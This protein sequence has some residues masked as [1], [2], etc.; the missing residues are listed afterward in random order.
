MLWQHAGGT[1]SI[2]IQ[3]EFGGDGGLEEA[4][5]LVE[6]YHIKWFGRV[7]HKTKQ[8]SRLAN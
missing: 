6:E 1:K 7:A 8:P 4:Y 2:I 3:Y 5:K